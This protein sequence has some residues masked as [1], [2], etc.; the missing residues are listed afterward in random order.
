MKIICNNKKA[1]FE[2]FL[3]D[4]YEAGIVLFGSE[5]KSIREGGVSLDQSFIFVQNGEIFLKNCYIKP[6]DKTTCYAPDIRRDRKL[7][8]NKQEIIKLETKV[9]TKGLTV[10]P[11]KVFISNKNLIKVDIALAQG[12]H[13]YDKKNTIKQRDVDREVKRQLANS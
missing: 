8:L 6:Y 2:Y 9:K 12:K 1:G 10:V 4:K 3:L 13:T 11:L 7:L 5:V